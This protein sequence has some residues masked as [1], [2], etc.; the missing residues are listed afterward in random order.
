[1]I[2]RI[3]RTELQNDGHRDE[4]GAH[5]PEHVVEAR[6]PERERVEE[7]LDR[8]ARRRE[9]AEEGPP[10]HFARDAH[11]AFPSVVVR[12]DACVAQARVGGAG[13]DDGR[14]GQE[15][16]GQAPT[17]SVVRDEMRPLWFRDRLPLRGRW[18]ESDSISLAHGTLDRDVLLLL[19]SLGL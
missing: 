12:V 14:H 4:R 18:R 3:P 1:M 13:R 6:A 9:Q 8:A 5:R 7:H 16:G 10:R 11:G 15:V 2:R 19:A 17:E